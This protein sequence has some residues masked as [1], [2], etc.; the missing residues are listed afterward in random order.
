PPSRKNVPRAMCRDVQTLRSREKRTRRESP[1]FSHAPATTRREGCDDACGSH[2]RKSATASLSCRSPLKQ[3]AHCGEAE[4]RHHDRADDMRANP[5]YAPQPFLAEN[6]CR[7]FAGERRK[8]GEPAEEA[9]RHQ[10]PD[11]RRQE[12]V[13]RNEF[14]RKAHEKSADQIGNERSER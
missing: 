5:K 13:S 9:R 6:E 3:R 8:R 4:E 14:H 11:I 12:R 10:Q 1:S 7:N 2:A